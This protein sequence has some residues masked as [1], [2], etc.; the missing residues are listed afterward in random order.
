MTFAI[1]Q[2]NP[3]TEEWY[4]MAGEHPTWKAADDFIDLV[5]DLNL[6]GGPHIR[7]RIVPVPP[8]ATAGNPPGRGYPVPLSVAPG[9]NS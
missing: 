8:P 9:G 4:R 2:Q 6:F 1:E 3:L 7:F 5:R